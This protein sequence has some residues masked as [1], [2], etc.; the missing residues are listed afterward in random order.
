MSRSSARLL[1]WSPRILAIAFTLFLALF[2]LDAFN[3]VQ[4][5]WQTVL[6][7]SLH[8]IPVAVV[9][10]ILIIAWRWEWVGAGLFALVALQYAL[11]VLPRHVDWALTIAA[12]LLLIAALFLT[13]WIERAK[14]RSAL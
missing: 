8:L 11:K 13:N 6:A 14:L 12:P 4:G 9:G 2:S 5:F 1:F 7:F 10:A 3:Q